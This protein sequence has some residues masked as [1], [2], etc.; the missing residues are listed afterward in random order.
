MM[1]TPETATR[2][3]ATAEKYQ[4]TAV[5]AEIDRRHRANKFKLSM[6]PTFPYDGPKFNF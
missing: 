5:K 2:A 4:Y 3:C 1:P 6:Y